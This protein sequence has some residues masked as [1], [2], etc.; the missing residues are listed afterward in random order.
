MH[1]RETLATT[2]AAPPAGNSHGAAVRTAESVS[3]VQPADPAGR[4]QA[5]APRG[6][7]IAAPISTARAAPRRVEKIYSARE[8]RP[9]GR[10]RRPAAGAKGRDREVKDAG[11]RSVAEE[12]SIFETRLVVCSA[13]RGEIAYAQRT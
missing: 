11:R 2:P 5:C 9:C 3:N 4:G 7:K 6:G 8:M 12:K 13:C 10:V 1:P